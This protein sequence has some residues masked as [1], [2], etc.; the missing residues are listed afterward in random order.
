M[1]DEK[2]F[3]QW[4]KDYDESVD[5]TE[6][7]EEYPFAGYDDIHDAICRIVAEKEAPVILD[8]GF[9]TGALTVRLYEGGASVW[10]QDFS[11][12]MIAIAREKMPEAHLFK[13]DF[14]E[15]LREPLLQNRYDFIIATY[16][17]HHL[18][19][20]KKPAFLREL[21]SLLK[22]DGL[23]LIGDV[24]FLNEEDRDACRRRAGER[25][26]DEEFY[27]VYDELCRVFPALRFRKMSHCAGLMQLGKE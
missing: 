13:G 23:I 3:D 4:A 2:G 21:Q 25:W 26:D 5:A 12:N 19:D 22:E 11:E 6:K 16:S 18:P 24:S 10:G 20:E 8:I 15:G 7:A 1:R 14:S 9:G 27:I 17:I